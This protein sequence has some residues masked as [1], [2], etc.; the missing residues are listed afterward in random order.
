MIG[1]DPN[2]EIS[3]CCAAIEKIRYPSR[4]DSVW[5][6]NGSRDRGA[7]GLLEMTWNYLELIAL[8]LDFT[9]PGQAEIQ[10]RQ[11]QNREEQS[12]PDRAS[13]A[14]LQA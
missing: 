13:I 4:A 7:L 14:H 6:V 8:R 2:T 11:Q 10:R 1:S 3:Q 9:P 12:Q 5:I